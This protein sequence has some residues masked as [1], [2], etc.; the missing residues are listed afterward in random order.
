M[1]AAANNIPP[2][3]MMLERFVSRR[4]D[5]ESFPDESKAPIRTSGATSWNA[6]FRFAFKLAEPPEISRL[7][8]QLPGFGGDPRRQLLSILSTHQHLALFRVGKI[9]V[10]GELPVQDLFIFSASDPCSIKLLPHCTLPILDVHTR[11]D[12]RQSR[13]RPT[14]PLP[15][16][17]VMSVAC[18]GLL[19]EGEKFVVAEAKLLVS[20]RNRSEVHADIFWLRSSDCK[21]KSVRTPIVSRD[22]T[23]DFRWQTYTVI[24]V[25]NWLCWIDYYNGILFGDFHESTPTLTLVRLP[26]ESPPTDLRIVG[27]CWMYRSVSAID[28][29]SRLKFIKVDRDDCIWYG[30][31]KE[32]AGF[33]ITC[34]TLSVKDKVWEEDYTVTSEELWSANSP[35]VLP[36]DILMFPQV[37]IDRPHVVHF[38]IIGES[39]Y[40]MK[41]MWVVTIDMKTKKVESFRQ[42]IKGREDHGTEDADLAEEK[43]YCPLPFLTCEFSKFLHLSR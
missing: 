32:D 28:A 27:S 2:K 13:H 42:Y 18:M 26:L 19:C 38:L 17:R 22:S 12:G 29:D 43:S 11:C 23:K 5:D 24:P 20:G 7:Y 10:D 36:H 37:N 33:T 30:P 25:G 34:H 21:W 39:K 31:L 4:D 9:S 41:K 35:E 14:L 15:E 3:W 1:S 6:P 16:K 40:L 8:A